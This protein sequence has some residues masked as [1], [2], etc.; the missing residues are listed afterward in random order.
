MTCIYGWRLYAADCA[1]RALS[2]YEREYPD[3]IRPR[4]AIV[5]ARL[6]AWG[7]VLQGEATRAA[8]EAASWRVARQVAA[9]WEDAWAAQAVIWAIDA[10]LTAS[11]REEGEA[12][13]QAA[14]WVV[15]SRVAWAS[16]QAS[17][18]AADWSATPEMTWARMSAASW[19]AADAA[20]AA[21]DAERVWQAAR[22]DE[23]LEGRV[24]LGEIRAQA[25]REWIELGGESEWEDAG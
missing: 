5:A 6:M 19:D 12:E 15:A 23:Y 16:A 10:V 8:D 17:A 7:D 13:A 9:S 20:A 14:A 2:L 4:R 1:E 18:R 25:R 24:D 22:L 21:A 3:D 11:S